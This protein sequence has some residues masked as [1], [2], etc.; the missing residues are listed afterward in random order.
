[1][2]TPMLTY[3]FVC[4][5]VLRYGAAC[6]PGYERER[7]KL[8][9]YLGIEWVPHGL[10]YTSQS[11]T[12]KIRHASDLNCNFENVRNCRW[13]NVDEH[14]HFDTLDFHLFEK[15]DFIEFPVL[16][17]QP[18]PSKLNQG[19]KMLFVG[20]RSRNEQ[21]AIW[22]SSVIGCQ[23]TTGVLSFTF[24]L[25]NGASVEVVLFEVR[26]DGKLHLLPEKPFVDC[27]TVHLNTDCE[28]EIHAR[29]IP[30]SIGIR[31]F[32][33]NNREG[34]FVMIDNIAYKAGLCKVSIDLGDDFESVPLRTLSTAD[35]I[36]EAKDLN[37]STFDENCK[38][39][40]YGGYSEA[41]RV[42]KTSPDSQRMFTA[43][44]TYVAPEAP[45]AFI[46]IEQD[47]TP[48]FNVLQSALIK[49]QTEESKFSFRFWASR[50]VVLEVCAI[51]MHFNERECHIVPMAQSPGLV[52]FTFGDHQNFQIVIRV[53]YVS[54]DFDSFVAIDDIGYSAIFCTDAIDAWDLGSDFYSAPMLSVLVRRPVFSA[55]DIECDFAKRAVNCFWGN[56]EDTTSAWLVGSTPINHHK[57]YSLTK[58]NIPPDGEFAL[59]RLEEGETADLL[60]EPVRCASDHT[61][62]SFR[63]WQTG[64]ARLSVCLLEDSLPAT[65]DCERLLLKAP[66]PAVID[67]P[68]MNY[69]FRISLKA[70]ATAKG[71]IIVDDIKLEGYICPSVAHLHGV[72][73]ANGVAPLPPDPN[74]CRLLTCNF[75]DGQTCL[76][77]STVVASSQSRFRASDGVV[78]AD[79][80]LKGKVAVLE[81]PTF[82][83]NSPAR[84]HFSYRKGESSSLFVCHDSFFRELDKCFEVGQNST[85]ITGWIK[86][87]MEIVPSDTKFYFIA[88]LQDNSR[89]AKVSVANVTLTDT[90]DH[91]ICT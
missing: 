75:L 10:D 74:V 44:G 38:W 45:Y 30:F 6:M 52:S 11:D 68:D 88:K 19:D 87:F 80:F 32:G 42:A 65:L 62:L 70:E 67:I 76:F 40:N 34:S 53:K 8:K 29:E 91:P 20:D 33:M 81:S 78:T 79:L 17:V 46:Y 24:W 35:Y 27:G 31:A 21:S 57:F 49:C 82:A 26:K 63:F 1:M 61:T 47:R 16:Q 72:R 50:N 28:A 56:T 85:A 89:R 5:G 83:L 12:R 86:D 4:F 41:W 55:K 36:F 18:G 7:M 60:T 71:M 84:V 9:E 43:T 37:C 69:P 58:T 54:V 90:D 3:W 59:V 2:S 51:D 77:T 13:K 64:G 66:G 23:N 14:E 22:R 73:T 39:R 15:T 48:P 25:Y